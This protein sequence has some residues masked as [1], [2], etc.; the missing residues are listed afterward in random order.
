MTVKYPKPLNRAAAPVVS[1]T[2][3]ER[4]RAVVALIK[5][6]HEGLRL[7]CQHYKINWKS[8]AANRFYTLAL[9]LAMDNVPYFQERKPR[10]K[11]WTFEKKAQLVL[12]VLDMQRRAR[13]F[14]RRYPRARTVSGACAALVKEGRYKQEGLVQR[15][16]EAIGSPIL[17]SLRMAGI[18]DDAYRRIFANAVGASTKKK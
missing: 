7:L 8:P 13:Q 14:P 11:V 9:H 5:Y 18:S 6:R 10:S 15:Y 1:F 17:R 12:D 3:E 2:R 4:N 16:K